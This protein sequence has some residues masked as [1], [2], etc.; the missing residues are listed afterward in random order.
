VG[1][2]DN[3]GLPEPLRD[4]LGAFG[5]TPPPLALEP[6]CAVIEADLGAA[7]GDLLRLLRTT[8]MAQGALGQV[9]RATLPDSTPVTVKIRR[10]EVSDSI[11]RD[12]DPA[13]LARR[14]AA[15]F[16]GGGQLAGL[17]TQLRD[18]A[19]MECDYA[20]AA[21]RQERLWWLFA[22]HP[23]IVVPSLKRAYCGARVL[24]AELPNGARFDKY[25]ASR[26]S[27]A[28]RDRTGEALFDFYLGTLFEHGLQHCDPHP[29]NHLFLPD[30][31]LA[32]VDFGCVR[33]LG[34]T[35]V[36]R[37]AA[38]THS[39]WADQS[40]LIHRA[41]VDLGLAAADERNDDEQARALLHA[42][43]GPLLR[44]EVATFEPPR[45]TLASVLE[46][47]RT[48][49][50]PP[51][52]TEVFFLLRTVLAL[53]LML[54]QLG[55]RANWYRRLQTLLGAHP[56]PSFDVVLL[57]P[58][59]STIVM[60]KELREAT[61]LPL[62][63]IEYLITKSPQTIKQAVPRAEAEALRMRLEKAGAQVEIKLVSV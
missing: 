32:F 47:W 25:L 59:H 6:V 22:S 52:A 61:G 8:P 56:Q 2:F 17:A 55:A 23:T 31:R 40:D 42:I 43:Y 34:P 14:L 48:A 15:W 33:E 20:L 46:R 63:E 37:I 4:G 36:R 27:Q 1:Y 16:G 30:G 54:G 62:R 57:H 35:M 5:T 13:T 41:L 3:L 38:L 24:T 60:T 18:L 19:L 50:V 21:Q 28:A 12:L 11:A 51:G 10:P 7:A 29:D 45:L 26:P 53:G 39:L 9:H 49:P 44:D 58:G